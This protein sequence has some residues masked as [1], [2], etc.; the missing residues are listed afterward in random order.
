MEQ[1]NKTLVPPPRK[2]PYEIDDSLWLNMKDLDWS[3]LTDGLTPKRYR[4]HQELFHQSNS[5]R[6]VYLCK[7][8]RVQL[9]IF[10]SNG[11]Q[12]ILFISGQNSMFGELNLFDHMPYSSTATTVTDCMIY[13]IPADIF[14]LR[15]KEHPEL[16]T[17]LIKTQSKKNRLLTTAI[18]QMSFND[19]T[20]RVAYALVNLIN[21]YSQP[22]KA[23]S[24]KLTLKYTHQNIADLTG[25]SRVSV[26]NIISK[27]Q[28][29][30][31]LKKDS[32]DGYIIIKDPEKLYGF[33]DDYKHDQ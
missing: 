1:K 22:L 15:L 23:G 24:Y 3:A 31:I 6:Y 4:A 33:L 14:F 5:S 2:N 12:R 9:S 28:N 17:N 7:S 13:V 32:L 29:M 8:G 30:G 11:N 21:D 19:A 20:Y 16:V 10:G 18:K 26:S 25:L 27:F